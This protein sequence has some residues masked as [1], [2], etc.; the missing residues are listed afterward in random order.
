MSFQVQDDW[1]VP[2][3]WGRHMTLQEILKSKR[4]ADIFILSRY[5]YR[6]GEPI[7][8]DELY[9]KVL[10]AINHFRPKE[11]IA[12]LN[13]TYD[14]D[15]VPVDLLKEIGVEPVKFFNAEE[16]ST[17]YH[18]LDEEKSLSINSVTTYLDAYKYFYRYCTEKQDI[19]V[20]LK[21]DGDNAKSLYVD[22]RLA[23]SLS[24]GR[25]GMG[26]D[27]TKQISSSLP[28]FIGKEFKEL[29]VYAEC[30]VDL[31]YL[32]T[33]RQKYNRDYK[34]AKSSA[35]SML[36]VKHAEEDYKHLNVIVHGVD[37]LADTVEETFKKAS[38]LGFSVVKH[39]LIHWAEVPLD[40]ELFKPWLKRNIFDYFYETTKGIPSDGIVLEVNDLKYIGTQKN[41]YS[42]R[43]LALKME[44]WS[45][46]CYRGIVKN[47]LW[48]QKR[49][50]ASCRI[51]IEPMKTADG[52]SAEFINCFNF[53]VLVRNNINIGSEI[54]Y[55]RNS[56]AVNILVYGEQL[57]K[58]LGRS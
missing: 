46:K 16:K 11:L 47:I 50:Y 39:K 22:G 18:Y 10:N 8:S 41:Q 29:K 28:K 49:V 4:L 53:S 40:F 2:I 7:I 38:E 54:Y 35:I 9:E 37:G 45:F 48:E 21:M 3:K 1:F 52:C 31:D 27:F 26:F 58:L 12:Y 57:E 56:D 24:R 55:V 44:Q 6:I 19:M 30:F 15:P 34:T 20:S 43:Q 25:S 36:R 33:L 51:Q 23:L 42:D 14:D 5:F 32:P 13:R 17:L